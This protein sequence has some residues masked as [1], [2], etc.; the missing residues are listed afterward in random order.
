[1]LQN[2]AIRGRA[3]PRAADFLRPLTTRLPSRACGSDFD[4]VHTDR[5]CV[6]TVS[7]GAKPTVLRSESVRLVLTVPTIPT[8]LA[9]RNLPAR[10][11]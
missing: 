4:W 1:V 11:F 5:F 2:L 8:V 6:S 10:S 7:A 9:G 3:S